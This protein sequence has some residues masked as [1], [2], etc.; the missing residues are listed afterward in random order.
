MKPTAIVASVILL[1]VLMAAGGEGNPNLKD[2]S[3]VAGVDKTTQYYMFILPDGFRTGQE[4]DLLVALH[5]HGSDRK[6]FATAARDECKAARDVAAKHQMIFISPDYRASTSWMG[7]KAEADV[8]QIITDLKKQF[9]VGKVFVCGASMGGA[10][11]LTFAVRR[12]DLVDGVASMNGTANLLEYEKFQDAR[13]VSF[14]G[15]KAELPLE[16]KN[17]SAEYWPERLTMPV[18]FTAGGK[19][20]AVPPQSV[21]R[22]AGVLKLLSRPVL[23]VYRE[24]G[25]HSTDYEDATAVLEFVIAK[26]KE[27]LPASSRPAAAPLSR[28]AVGPSSRPVARANVGGGT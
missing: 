3:F 20:D 4:H 9:R 8:A 15:T 13:T 18:A 24:G 22:L 11:C 12:P 21:L 23:M 6:Q 14:G 7:P 10:A 19:D 2:V 1:V 27:P 16:Y 17:R 26:A 5:G 28:P 25:G